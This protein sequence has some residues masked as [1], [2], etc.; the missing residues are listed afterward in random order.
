[1]A[2]PRPSD[3]QTSNITE[4]SDAL[5]IRRFLEEGNQSA[6]EALIHRHAASLYR[7]LYSMVTS[8][9]DSEDLS[10]LTFA[11]A[12]SALPTYVDD[13]RFR[14]WLFRIGKN[15]AL[16]LIRKRGSR[17]QIER[18]LEEN[19]LEAPSAAEE[20]HSR[21]SVETIL[22]AVKDLPP[23]E[24]NVVHLRIREGLS[25]REIAELT[26]SPLGTVLSRMQQ[27]RQRLRGKLK[28]ILE[29]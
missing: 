9:Q 4:V 28:P 1:M 29:S 16:G 21:S 18:E 13:G 20:V 14:A 12:F 3:P 27:A 11:R 23:A 2:N 25:F 15:E 19:D 8:V 10:Q 7:F 26:D 5:L 24:R 17:P 22:E 6:G